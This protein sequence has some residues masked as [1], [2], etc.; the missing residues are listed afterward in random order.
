VPRNIYR[1]VEFL[2]F[3]PISVRRAIPG[4]LTIIA[5]GT[6]LDNLFP[7]AVGIECWLQYTRPHPKNSLTERAS[8][9]ETGRFMAAVR[10][11]VIKRFWCGKVVRNR[12]R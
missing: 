12:S 11:H 3:I 6:D 7:V 1:P 8:G 10:S 4:S 9:P 5:V 2:G